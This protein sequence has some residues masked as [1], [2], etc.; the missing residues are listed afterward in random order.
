MLRRTKREK[1][2]K[3]KHLAQEKRWTGRDEREQIKVSNDSGEQG[4]WKGTV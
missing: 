2:L 1:G 4:V 3:Y